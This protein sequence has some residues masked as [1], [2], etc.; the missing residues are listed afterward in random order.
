MKKL[1]LL[2]FA[3]FVYSLGYTQSS[4]TTAG[5]TSGNFE[6]S[7]TGAA[8]YNV[9]F[10]MLPGIN[11]LVPQIGLTYSSQGSNGLAGWGWNI[12]GLSTI[13]RIPSTTYHDGEIDPVDFDIMDRFALDG[14]RLILK[15]GNYGQ[16]G[17]VYETENYSNIRITSYGTSP[18][19]S[20]YGPSYFKVEYP[21]G[22]RAWYGLAG[23]S[24]NKLEWALH[25]T[26]DINE[27]FIQY[28]YLISNGLL[29]IHMIR[30][31]TRQPNTSF[32]NVVQF[33][34]KTRSR[35]EHSYVGGES[36]KRTN[37][38]DNVQVLGGGQ[39]YR[40]YEITHTQTNLEYQKITQI[41]ES[42]EDNE[43]FAPINFT[44][45]SNSSEAD[46]QKN[47]L[48]NMSHQPL[49]SEN[50][51]IIPGD[52]TGDGLVDFFAFDRTDKDH[53][54]Y[55][56]NIKMGANSDY[57]RYNFS[58]D[59]EAVF[60]IRYLEGGKLKETQGLTLVKETLNNSFAQVTF[61]TR[62]ITP[63]GFQ[64]QNS[65]T[66]SASG[67]HFDVS[68]SIDSHSK[69]PKRYISGD[70]DG[71]SITDI[72][73]I[74]ESHTNRYCNT[75]NFN[76]SNSEF[77]PGECEPGDPDY[78]NCNSGGCGCSET[79]QPQKTYFVNLREDQPSGFVQYLGSSF[80]FQANKRIQTGDFNGDGKTDLFYFENGR[81]KVYEFKN[82][83][84]TLIENKPSSKINDNLPVLLGDYNG[85]GKTDFATPQ[86]QGS[87]N[88]TFFMSNGN[89]FLEYTRNTPM[90][91]AETNVGNGNYLNEY[92]FIS[93]DFN[94][95]GKTDILYHYVGSNNTDFS[96][97]RV[98]RIYKNIFNGD[99]ASTNFEF[100][101]SKTE[102]DSSTN[103][104]GI[105]LIL[106][107]NQ[108][109]EN[110]EYAFIAHSKIH[111][112]NIK[113]DR[114]NL[115]LTSITNNGLQTSIIYDNVL[116]EPDAEPNF[117]YGKDYDE[118]YPYININVAPN[119]KVVREVE[120]S[121]SS[122]TQKQEYF[123]EG[124]VS[125]AHG[126]GF[127]GFKGVHRTNWYGTD[128]A[129]LWTVT[130]HD[131]QK[132]NAVTLQWT[133][134]LFSQTLPSYINKTDYSFNTTISSS[135]V[136]TNLPTTITK[137]DALQ[138]IS[139]T[140]TYTYDSY[141]NPSTVNSSMTGGISSTK[142]IHYYDNPS[143]SN[144]NYYIGRPWRI[145]ESNTIDGDTF[146]T[147]TRHTYSSNRISLTKTMGNNTDWL[148]ESF[149]YDLFGNLTRKT[150]YASDVSN[151]E[152][153]FEYDVSGRY[154]TKS[155]DIE[156]LENTF[157]Y[158]SFNGEL[159]SETNPYGLTVSYQYDGWNRVT[160]ETDYLG[161]HT[162]ISYALEFFPGSGNTYRIITDFPEGKDTVELFNVFEWQV[163]AKARALNN[164]WTQVETK[165]DSSGKE[166]QTSEPY[167]SGGSATQWNSI[168][169]D[170]YGRPITQVLYT[171]KI[172]NTSYSGLNVTVDD[173]TKT[174][175]T[176]K[177]AA[178]HIKVLTDDGGTISYNY[179]GNG[180]MRQ[181]N[182]GSHSVTLT[183]DG[184][185]R[186]ASL[187]DPSAGTYTYTYNTLGEIL[188]EQS[189]K[190][191]TSYVYDDFGK[192]ETKTLQGHETNMNITYS[193][194]ATTKKLDAIRGDDLQFS[195]LFNYTYEYDNYERPLVITESSNNADYEYSMTYDALG[196]VNTER[197]IINN[198]IT[199]VS[200]DVH[201]KNLF[202][203]HGNLVRISDN[204]SNA[205]LW[206]INT[207]NARGQATS[208]TFGNDIERENSYDAYGL[209]TEILDR[210]DATGIQALRMEYDFNAQRGILNSRKNYNFTN[211]D[212]TF[213]HDSLDR[214]T[215]IS[216]ATSHTQTY[217]QRGRILNNSIVG[218]Y[219]YDNQKLYQLKEVDLNNQGDLF[220]Q[221][222]TANQ[223]IKYNMFKMPTEV[224]I[225]GKGSAFFEYNPMNGRSDAFYGSLGSNSTQ[226]AYHK[227]YSS[228]MPVEMTEN[229]TTG[230]TKIVTY[231]G[232][233]AYTAPIAHISKSNTNPQ[234]SKYH[235]LHRDYLG[236]ILAVSDENGQVLEERQF[237]A[238]GS[239]DQYNSTTNTSFDQDS[240][241][242]RGFTGHEHFFGVGLVH[243]NGRLYDAKLGRFLSPDNFVQDPYNTQSFNRYGYVWNNPLV[244]NDPNGEFIL[245]A[246]AIAAVVF[247]VGNV[248]AQAIQGNIHS[249]G[250]ALGF[251]AQGALAGA[252]SAVGAIL[253]SSVPILGPIVGAFVA[254][255]G[256]VQVAGLV[257]G[258]AQ[259]IF[260]GS[261]DKF[262]N[263]S[264]LFLGNFYLDENRTF[265]G[266]VLQG[267]SRHSYE[268][269]QTNLGS[270]IANVKNALGQ[271]D[272]VDYF[273]GATFATNENTER[274]NGVSL[275]NFI[276][277]NLRN[278]IN[279]NISFEDFVIQT[280]LYR[281]EYGHTFD[282][283]IFG[284]SYLLAVGIPSAISTLLDR[285][286]LFNHEHDDLYAERWADRHAE[287][288]FRK[289]F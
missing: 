4:M 275:G 269:L 199:G 201:V 154:L 168:T 123:Y 238:W 58:S 134:N 236:S 85:D 239:I 2:L 28:D 40:K 27:N 91:Y 144:A 164:Q 285:W 193:Y 240:I 67:R 247:A 210:D 280:D 232:G 81:I 167:F 253:I 215:Q 162:F 259:G 234:T 90:L 111:S 60:P 53:L 217:D 278:E 273:G 212:E 74:Q 219:S 142:T 89:D 112:Y 6:V 39:L 222:R 191:T 51:S 229:R 114:K 116:D 173:G 47:D 35:F 139:S 156:G 194:D 277:I 59:F 34:Y 107:T 264:K 159:I 17:A 184:W 272:R 228:I 82:N 205:L 64:V 63:S 261:W 135:K 30:Y 267:A 255:N 185:G 117:S 56:S 140:E 23:N 45:D 245:T 105:P 96:G 14:Q 271:V 251:F 279:N 113:D 274:Q 188:T 241:I 37:I 86:A 143:G 122:I 141:N 227:Q 147:E 209:L 128:V 119:L 160:R 265:F 176:T 231:I 7:L 270:T 69:I 8:T 100:V 192:I 3:F 252:I 149:G 36:F 83:N 216:G 22:T 99:N 65:K 98:I 94:G 150:V 157:N 115:E 129:R 226:M 218:N 95:D 43:T 145:I 125:T 19:G 180:S 16:S 138:G 26:I 103:R 108:A 121:G 136:F 243:M 102:N 80:N 151:R 242:T 9:P 284:L 161:N 158:N 48:I 195:K 250:D 148:N 124:A 178:N 66:W 71:D 10:K 5:T 75:N 84:L 131:P 170:Q 186:K 171:G 152:E 256:A 13:T 197:Y 187:N 196:R 246:I 257:V 11:N 46:I 163:G 254:V 289:H 120:R 165:Y 223:I 42:N 203:T 92:H 221:H 207:Q 104:Y 183:I 214:L 182:Y 61:E 200:S 73:V 127:L 15:S 155:I 79:T 21:N 179:F 68:C 32:P 286:D 283:Q 31:G 44:Y 133:A 52:F 266:G 106:E 146:S 33:N 41:V 281:H 93:Q 208:I 76:K 57:T 198:M 97:Q 268:V 237:G 166:L 137:T 204:L 190:G 233:D 78:P 50:H 72:I 260:G 24:R 130:K 172:I 29:R 110:L 189:T 12:S 220:Y 38:L 258:A 169:Y 101:G 177:D 248:V 262:Q 225:E 213:T 132:R 88:W 174:I 224:Q 77:I 18:Y 1:L 202:D 282:S 62:A 55:Y 175:S 249:F 206:E 211:W 109:N 20:E 118:L 276:N 288:Y 263:A 153:R 54:H 244:N 181:A 287:R 126:L 87:Y 49:T 235:Y 70:F 230:E 25:K